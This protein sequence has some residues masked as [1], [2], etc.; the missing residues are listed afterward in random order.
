MTLSKITSSLLRRHRLRDYDR[1]FRQYL[2]D[3][4]RNDEKKLA[5]QFRKWEMKDY[6]IQL[7]SGMPK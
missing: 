6:E 3:K 4:K 2:V 1:Y 5:E 7:K